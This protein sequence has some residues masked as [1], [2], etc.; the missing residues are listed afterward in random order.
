MAEHNEPDTN[1]QTIYVINTFEGAHHFFNHRTDIDP[2]DIVSHEDEILTNIYKVKEWEY[3]PFFITFGHHFIMDF[4]AMQNP[5][6]ILS[7]IADPS[8]MDDGHWYEFIGWKVVQALL[9][10]SGGKEFIDIKHMSYKSRIEYI[11]YLKTNY[12]DEYAAKQIPL[13]ISH[14]ACKWIIQ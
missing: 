12:P 4:A 5:L 3:K 7:R 10:N 2:N 6:P 14:G 8:G 13:I 9:D 11:R 1:I